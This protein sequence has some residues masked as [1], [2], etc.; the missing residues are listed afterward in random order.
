MSPMDREIDV[1][2]DVGGN[3]LRI[4][5]VGQMACRMPAGEGWAGKRDNRH[6]HPE[7]F[8]SCQAA[9]VR[10]GIEGQ[11]DPVIGIE[12]LARRRPRLKTYAS[13]RNVSLSELDLDSVLQLTLL[14]ATV[15]KQELRVRDAVQD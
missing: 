14:K 15:A 6:A 7:R 2:I 13:G 10:L 3:E 9:R 8:A 4:A 12:Q 5:G 11:V 1:A